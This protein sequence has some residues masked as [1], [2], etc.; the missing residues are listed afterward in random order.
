MTPAG[1]N[2][3]IDVGSPPFR[4]AQGPEH[5]EGLVGGPFLDRIVARRSSVAK[6]MED[7]PSGG[8]AMRATAHH[9]VIA[10]ITRKMRFDCIVAARPDARRWRRGFPW[11][12]E[13][14]GKCH[15]AS[16]P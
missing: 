9:V 6:P 8:P 4:Q 2:D 10:E 15:A 14:S 5:V 13:F 7:R 12:P 11:R 3:A 16:A 1:W